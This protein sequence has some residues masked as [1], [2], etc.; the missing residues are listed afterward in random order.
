MSSKSSFLVGIVGGFLVLCAIG[1]FILLGVYLKT[2]F[3]GS[4]N[5]ASTVVKIPTTNTNT[6]TG[7]TNTGTTDIK[8]AD[9][10]STDHIRG[11]KDAKV[12]VIEF[13][14]SECPF[15]KRFHTTMLEVMKSYGDKIRWVYKHAPLDSLH[16]NAR[17]EA[18]A[19]ECAAEIGGNAGFWKFTD[20]LYEIT[21]SNDGLAASQLPEIAKY[22]GIDVTKF[23]TCLSSGKHA[24]AVQT[25]LNE[26]QAAGLQGT[27]YSVVVGNGQ[28]IPVSGAYPASEMKTIIDSLLK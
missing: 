4:T 7:T 27:P 18:E 2:G 11:G 14:D 9:I 6:E 28:K 26:A 15:C 10:K 23:N 19:M 21:P 24:T 1:F 12:T 5:T 8:L 3:K 22:A 17:K 16:A 25:Q 13:S 20:R